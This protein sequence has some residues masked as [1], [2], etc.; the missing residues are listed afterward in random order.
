M[1]KN[2]FSIIKIT[3]STNVSQHLFLFVLILILLFLIAITK[4]RQTIHEKNNGHKSNSNPL[5]DQ[6]WSLE[7]EINKIISDA[8]NPNKI[9]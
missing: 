7:S 8:I 6:C 5:I 3:E 2:I 1:L 4:I 9:F